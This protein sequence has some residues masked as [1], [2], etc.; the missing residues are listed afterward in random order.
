MGMTITQASDIYSVGIMLYEMLAGQPPYT[1]K[2]V[3][4]ILLAHQNRESPEAVPSRPRDIA[5]DWKGSF[6]P[7]SNGTSSADIATA[8]V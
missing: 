6:S 7:A 4:E 2:S 5:R 3:M 8:K 1:G